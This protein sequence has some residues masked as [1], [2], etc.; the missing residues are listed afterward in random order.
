MTRR[1][2]VLGASRQLAEVLASDDRG[3]VAAL[4]DPEFRAVG[5]DGREWLGADALPHL[6]PTPAPD[7]LRVYGDVALLIGRDAVDG[8]E[9]ATVEVWVRRDGDGDWRLIVR[10]INI[11]AAPDAPSGRPAHTPRPADAPP[12]RCANPVEQV[13]YE[14]VSE[15]ER[16]ILHSFQTL[17]GHV[18]R[19]EAD[20]W[21]RYVA[22]EFVVFRTGQHPTT[23]AE[24]AAHLREQ[25]AI[26]AE[27]HVAEVET[28]W[29]R[30]FGDAAVMRA[31]HVM[32]GNRRPPYRATRVWVRRDGV[33]QMAV[34][35]Q[36]TR[37]A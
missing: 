33:W 35:Q 1:S 8:G 15:A 25:K 6:E 22:E 13:P 29:M 34:S 16:G 17:E 20:D 3:G 10:Q 28:M 11:I 21:V 14:P 36:T 18:I 19:N 4:L 5:R 24:R 37:A 31:D 7:D 12:P 27:I 2:D 23:R 26:N 9:R 32:P 30:V